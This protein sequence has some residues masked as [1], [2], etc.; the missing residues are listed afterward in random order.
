[1]E[2]GIT[3]RFSSFEPRNLV[4]TSLSNYST[5]PPILGNNVKTKIRTGVA[6]KRQTRHSL[7]LSKSPEISGF[8]IRSYYLNHPKDLSFKQRI[9]NLR[10]DVNLS[11]DLNQKSTAEFLIVKQSKISLYE[12]YQTRKKKLKTLF[13][14][15]NHSNLD[16][17]R[18][19]KKS[20]EK[21]HFKEA[22]KDKDWVLSI[23]PQ[24]SSNFSKLIC[25]SNAIEVNFNPEDYPTFKFS[26]GQGNNSKLVKQVMSKRW[27][28]SRVPVSESS[29]SNFAWTQWRDQSFLDS[30]PSSCNVSHSKYPFNGDFKNEVL[31]IKNLT[32]KKIVDISCLGFEKI[33]KSRSFTIMDVRSKVNVG[34]RIHNRVDKNFMLANKKAL[35][36]NLRNYY[37]ALGLDPFEFIPLTFHVSCESDKEFDRFLRRFEEF[38]EGSL[39]ILKPGENSNR[40]NGIC[41]VSSVKEVREHIKVNPFPVTGQHTYIIQKYIE[42]PLLINKRK[43]DIRC[44]ALLTSINGVIQCYLYEDG[45]IRTSSKK[46]SCSDPQDLFIHLTNDAIQKKGESYGKYESGNKMTYSDLQ[47]YLDSLQSPKPHFTLQVLPKIKSLIQDSIKSVFLKLDPSKRTHSFEIFGYDFMLDSD[48]KPWLIEVNTNPCLELSCSCLAKIIPNMLDNA[49]RI[50]LDPLF[51]EPKLGPKRSGVIPQNKFELIFHS[52]VDGVELVESLMQSGK[53]YL[54]Q[55]VETCLV[56]MNENLE[57]SEVGDDEEMD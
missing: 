9:S 31:Y 45:Y 46:F 1:M 30:L 43:F 4:I 2:S 12:A 47:K 52:Y 53:L 25:K 13:L 44:F 8:S 34:Q 36:Y 10:R 57:S 26:L 29:T 50:C 6:S 21:I 37:N 5:S 42:N 32:G 24:I 48:L 33:T 39:W 40:G 22:C 7:N 49:F 56:G 35:F 11:L 3:N 38:G 14:S 23:K 16:K 54:I 18:K 19:Q 28:W 20:F 51:P 15:L 17:T 41:I 55:E 27:W